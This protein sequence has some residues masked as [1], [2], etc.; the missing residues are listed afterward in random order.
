MD[1]IFQDQLLVT[2]DNYY[3]MIRRKSG[4]LPGCSAQLGALVAGADDVVCGQSYEVGCKLGMGLQ[5]VQDISDIWGPQGDGMM[6][7]N[8]LNKKKSL[9]EIYA[10]ENA[11][12]SVKRELG[13][14]YLKRVLEPQDV[15]RVVTMLDQARAR[16]Y[17]ENQA[18]MLVQQALDSL[19]NMGL[20]PERSEAIH[21]LGSVILGN[22]A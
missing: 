13:A 1:L 5:I 7:S 3:D 18:Q 17:A 22:N 10:L 11:T 19:G 20:T 8:V 21:H 6:V 12:R 9:P 15:T 14:I 2:S 16:E 4:A